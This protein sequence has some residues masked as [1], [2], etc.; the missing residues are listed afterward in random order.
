M[1]EKIRNFLKKDP[2]MIDINPDRENLK[3]VLCWRV[4]TFF[5]STA[6]AYLYLNELYSTLEMVAVEAV[7]LTTIHYIFE[8]LWSKNE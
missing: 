1:L 2:E 3:K 5:I 6:I 8:E 7:I 4:V